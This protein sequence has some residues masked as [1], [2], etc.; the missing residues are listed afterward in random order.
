MRRFYILWYMLAFQVAHLNAQD[1]LMF[2]NRIFNFQ[3]LYN[4]HQP[5]NDLA[6]RFGNFN[7]VGF[8]GHYKTRSNWT[9]SLEGNFLF[10]SDL[11]ETGLFNNL[12]TT[13]GFIAS[14]N[15]SPGNYT[16]A[17][18]GLSFFASG[19]RLFALNRRNPNSGIMVSGGIG[20]LQHQLL[21]NSKENNIPQFDANYVKGYD[22]LS[23]GIAFREFVG[24]AFQSPNRLINFYIGVEAMQASTVSRRGYNYDQMAADNKDR[25]DHTLSFR[26]GWMIPIYLNNP[27]EDEYQ[28]R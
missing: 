9:A 6:S 20:Y 1:R 5:S 3:F 19:G 13:G 2:S 28:F 11:K 15:G 24:Y 14:S 17:M 10:G 7:G 8:G 12:I 18:R 22:R 26:F 21:I 16:V 27:D 23:S 25:K 4:Y